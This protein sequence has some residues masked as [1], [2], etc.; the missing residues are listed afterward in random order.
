MCATQFTPEL[1]ATHCKHLH[2]TTKSL[3]FVYCWHNNLEFILFQ[4]SPYRTRTFQSEKP[5]H[6]YFVNFL[7]QFMAALFISDSLYF[8]FKGRQFCRSI[9]ELE[10]AQEN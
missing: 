5:C 10:P 4:A 6:L 9:V 1:I 8:F 3:L 2:S 7:A